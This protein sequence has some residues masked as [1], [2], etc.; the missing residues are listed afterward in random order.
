M[1]NKE[2]RNFPHRFSISNYIR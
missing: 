1:H 2:I